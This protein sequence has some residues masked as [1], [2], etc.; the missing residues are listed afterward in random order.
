ML[1]VPELQI[2]EV[3]R[4]GFAKLEKQITMLDE[5]L[6]A[7][8]KKMRDEAK[9]YLVGHNISIVQGF[10]KGGFTLPIIAIVD[11]GDREADD[12][13]TLNDFLMNWEVEEGDREELELYGI[14]RQANY[15]LLC[16]SSDPRLTLYM[17]LFVDTLIIL[18]R[19][20]LEAHGMMN[21]ITSS[22]DLSFEANL[23]PEWVGAKMVT[24]SCLHY[25]AVQV[26]SELL[27]Q[28]VV[29]VTVD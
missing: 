14:A 7:Y 1:V 16:Q 25:H 24:L 28:L 26:S 27:T 20:V 23:L 19:P 29:T 6:S 17:K 15:Q 11:G 4:N 18:N 3:L 13:D 12:K 21:I 10:P 22:S 9:K 8:P 5:L 2:E